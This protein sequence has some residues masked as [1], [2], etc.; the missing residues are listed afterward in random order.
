MNEVILDASAFLALVNRET[1]CEVVQDVIS[2][3]VMSS[4]NVAEVVAE[5]NFRLSIP[6]DK[7][8]K[9]IN[10]LVRIVDFNC[11]QAILSASLK[12]TTSHLRLSLGDRA[13][14][15]LGIALGLPVYTA[16]RIWS[17]LNLDLEI[18]VIR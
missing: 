2:R 3:S 4:V 11:R 13:C 18:I 12:K 5:L 10:S 6:I 1:G 8:E 7:A 17:K 16:D 9:M 14:I 15:G